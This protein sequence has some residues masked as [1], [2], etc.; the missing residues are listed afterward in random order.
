MP[1]PSTA[2]E[3][4]VCPSRTSIPGWP[5]IRSRTAAASATGLMAAS[6]VSNTANAI[7]GSKL[8]SHSAALH[9]RGGG[10]RSAPK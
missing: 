5:A 3:R 10:P 2:A 4:T 8:A 1:S 7:A 9:R 6:G